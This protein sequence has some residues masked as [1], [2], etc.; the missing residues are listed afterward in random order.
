[1][2]KALLVSCMGLLPAAANTADLPQK[3]P[4]P[5]AAAVYLSANQLDD[6]MRKA[7]SSGMQPAL[8]QIANTDQYFINR[9]HRTRVLPANVHAGW[10]EVHIIL[11]GSGTLATGGKL[12]VVEGANS[13]EG[14]M[15]RKV[16]KGDIIIVPADTPHQY[17]A[18][19][20][21]LDAIEVRF[22]AP[23]NDPPVKGDR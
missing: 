3:A 10:T 7:I 17:T 21:A 11:E 15:S 1:M 16:S 20:G 2:Y 14:G 23:P 19:D 6:V 9:V 8:S 18:I 13:I 12:K 5:G 4:P 22:I